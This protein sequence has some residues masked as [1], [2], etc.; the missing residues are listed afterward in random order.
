MLYISDLKTLDSTERFDPRLA[1]SQHI[2]EPTAQCRGN[3][4][5]LIIYIWC[6]SRI[7]SRLD[8][9]RAEN[10]PLSPIVQV[11]RATAQARHHHMCC[12][13]TNSLR[14][15]E[16]CTAHRFLSRSHTIRLNMSQILFADSASQPLVSRSPALR[17]PSSRQQQQDPNRYS[18]TLT[19]KLRSR[20]LSNTKNDKTE[21]SVD[22]SRK[23]L[24]VLHNPTR[25]KVV[26]RQGTL[27]ITSWTL[28]GVVLNF[29]DMRIV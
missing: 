25:G 29:T 14:V 27:E 6:S 11:Y 22:A 21:S 20:P 17:Y 7:H 23:T 18:T 24:G 26:L 3:A 12:C 9:R 2:H 4:K 5:R 19:P 13:N 16:T 15:T 8:A 28:D 1:T 10:V